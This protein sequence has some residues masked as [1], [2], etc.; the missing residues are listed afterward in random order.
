[1]IVSD[2]ALTVTDLL[3]SF[4]ARSLFHIA[5][6]QDIRLG[7]TRHNRG[8]I[9]MV[10]WR[11]ADLLVFFDIN[12]VF[13]VALFSDGALVAKCACGR[14]WQAGQSGACSH[15]VATLMSLIHVLRPDYFR[16]PN[17]PSS[18]IKNDHVIK[19]ILGQSV[20]HFEL[21]L[22]LNGMMA[23]F[24]LLADKECIPPEHPLFP[25][26]Y[27]PY[28][29]KRPGVLGPD[30]S[31][32]WEFVFS[33]FGT[34]CLVVEDEDTH[35]PVL[36]QAEPVTDLKVS[37][38]LV[39]SRIEFRAL[40]EGFWLG[41]VAYFNKKKKILA[42]LQVLPMVLNYVDAIRFN[43]S[44]LLGDAYKYFFGRDSEN[45]WKTSTVKFSR[46]MFN[47]QSPLIRDSDFRT[48][49]QAIQL[50]VKKEA[51]TPD[52]V[53]VTV[54]LNCEQQGSLFRMG[55]HIDPDGLCGGVDLQGFI[56]TTNQSAND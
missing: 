20:Q 2:T 25:D 39:A 30:P 37:L 24:V 10:H 32:F 40:D 1:M 46:Q 49:S 50:Y 38:H 42:P 11:G 45:F 12:S 54:R 56:N 29:Y 15:I 31:P 8:D 17:E 7:A 5:L 35:Y 22:D 34:H 21:G 23:A 55:I 19:Q 36:I 13:Q 41:N 26:V 51:V 48:V 47:G 9:G 53:P 16:V 44:L 18:R 14:S 33:S 3:M 52:I 4:D 27:S 28:F 6:P 43:Q